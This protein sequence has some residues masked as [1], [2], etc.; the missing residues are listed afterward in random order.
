MLDENNDPVVESE[1]AVDTDETTAESEEKSSS[2]E[3]VVYTQ[4]ENEPTKKDE[5]DEDDTPE[6]ISLEEIVEVE[7]KKSAHDDF[8]WTIGRKHSLAYDEKEIQKYLNDY[9]QSLKKLQEFSIVKGRVSAITPSDVV[10]DINYKSDGL[11]SS[12]EFR[13]M[14]ELAVGDEVEVYVEQTEDEK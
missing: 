1:E 8:D 9:D 6:Q 11:V 7:E 13:D 4:E 12:S 2:D 3:V 14:P 5:E 10:L